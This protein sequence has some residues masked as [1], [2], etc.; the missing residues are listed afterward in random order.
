MKA[1]KLL[2]LSI[3]SFAGVANNTA[4]AQVSLEAGDY[5]FYNVGTGKWLCGANS[6]GTQ[7]SMGEHGHFF[8]VNQVSSGVFTLDS[9]VY[10]SA[11]GHF[12]NGTYVDGASTNIYITSVGSGVYNLSTANGSAYVVASAT[13]EIVANTGTST[14]AQTDLAKWKIY[15]KQDIL[16]MCSSASA[17]NPVDVT[18][19]V[20]AANFGRNCYNA[21]YT[22]TPWAIENCTNYNLSG[23]NNT[24]NCAESFH[25][26]F[27][28]YQKLTDMPKGL[29]KMGGQGFYRQD[30]TDNT[31]LPVFFLNDNTK[32][33]PQKTGSENSMS[34]ASASFTSGLYAIDQIQANV[35]DGTI[36]I[37]VSLTSNLNL[38]CI[39][40][41]ISLYYYGPVSDLGV[42]KS[43]LADEVTK[44][45]AISGTMN[46]TV[47]SAL[48]SAISSYDGK[49]FDTVAKYETAISKLKTAIDNANTSVSNYS[50]V[51]KY[52][53]LKGALD[54]DGQAKYTATT[55]LNNL[56]TTYNN[57]TFTQADNSLL[58]ELEEAA[59]EAVRAQ[60]VGS[61]MTY[62]ITNP[63]FET[64][65]MTGWTVDGQGDTGAKST[66]NSVYA[67]QGSD[68]D[69]LFNTWNNGVGYALSQKITKLPA[70]KYKVTAVVGTDAGKKI[71]LNANNSKAS[72][73][74]SASGKGVGVTASCEAFV[75]DG[76]LT[77]SV[78]TTDDSWYK[79]DKF[80]L[81]YLAEVSEESY[82]QQIEELIKKSNTLLKSKMGTSAS[83]DLTGAINSAKGHATVEDLDALE[84]Y[85]Q[86]LT[87][88][89][90]AAESSVSAYESAKSCLDEID[91]IFERT[92][93]YKTAAYN[94]F[95]TERTTFETAYT[96]GTLTAA[97]ITE[98]RNSVFGT[99]WHSANTIDNVLLSP[100]GL[101]DDYTTKF[102]V[103]TWSVEAD[104]K[105][106][107]SGMTTPFVE[108]WAAD[109]STLDAT[110]LSAMFPG[111]NAGTYK[112]SV[113]V[114][115]RL[116]NGVTDEPTG[117]TFS[118]NGGTAV[119]VCK[120][121]TC[122]DGAQFR[123]DT[124]STTVTLAKKGV[125][126]VAFN[127][128]EGNNISWLAFRD[129][130]YV[131]DDTPAVSGDANGDGKVDVADVAALVNMA[132]GTTTATAAADVNGDGKVNISDIQ[133]LVDKILGK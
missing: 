9:H 89:Y 48:S 17:S 11:T 34:D 1:N 129:I 81:T 55:S 94:T 6:W 127:V 79:A 26:Q 14:D 86:N 40:D 68:G 43:I 29:Y 88:M 72:V 44:A 51:K 107:G 62:L 64:G 50:A 49:T 87:D 131:I 21:K 90:S 113:L 104:N 124:Y 97:Q 102:Y 46:K 10:N 119:D 63:S 95:N 58:A 111:V 70:G 37:G 121:K 98:Y 76:N 100:W 22:T 130:K 105:V 52:V 32:E 18:P 117:I 74:S 123:Y 66:S 7:A 91:E 71:T 110:S 23:G 126:N 45:K 3:L 5:L 116:S 13:S 15:S 80:T 125:L 101:S 93:Y 36:E 108:Y 12:F 39:W 83:S 120:G 128:L 133:A 103:N 132:I 77:I 114:R 65:D 27:K 2:L 96:E 4:D 112:V 118:V 35:T 60:G 109:A 73:D 20:L 19:L 30:G 24:N 122:D 106:N 61:D 56:W 92:N 33:F 82:H 84:G 25:S 54:A 57:G 47:A 28:I 8:Q 85:I 59:K 16:D 69:Y 42:Y 67:M 53:D 38:W 31:N 99:G 115:V 75:S 78:A 41:N